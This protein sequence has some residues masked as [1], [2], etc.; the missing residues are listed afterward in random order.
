MKKTQ[1]PNTEHTLAVARG[2]VVGGMGDMD[3]GD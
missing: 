1:T 3:K 2:E